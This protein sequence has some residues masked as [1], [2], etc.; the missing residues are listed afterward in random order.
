[1][2][3]TVTKTLRQIKHDFFFAAYSFVSQGGYLETVDSHTDAGHLLVYIMELTTSVLTAL[4]TANLAAFFTANRAVEPNV[5]SLQ[6]LI[7]QGGRIC[8]QRDTVIANALQI[9]VNQGNIPDWA[10]LY[11]EPATGGDYWTELRESHRIAFDHLREGNCLGYALPQ[12]LAEDSLVSSLNAPCDMRVVYPSFAANR[13]GY[14]TARPLLRARVPNATANAIC[15]SQLVEPVVGSLLR[16]VTFDPSQPIRRLRAQQTQTLRENS[17]NFD[18]S[19]FTGA[20]DKQQI[21]FS[22]VRTMFF[23]IC[24]VTLAL[25]FVSPRGRHRLERLLFRI[26]KCLSRVAHPPEPPHYK[27][28]RKS[29]DEWKLYRRGSRAKEDAQN[30]VLQQVLNEKIE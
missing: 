28:R 29:A 19:P 26:R 30:E 21:H 23:I 11:I 1:M 16:L 7:G 6:D 25:I 2:Y 10:L 5:N 8:V 9:G 12:W 24:M 3:S 20:N 4:Y 13:G 27:H 14:I 15:A 17:C 18:V 22:D